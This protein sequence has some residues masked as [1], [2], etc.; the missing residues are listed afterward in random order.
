MLDTSYERFFATLANE[1]RL[2]IVQHLSKSGP[3]SV[4]DIVKATSLEQ[5]LV[6]RHMQRLLSCH[7]VSVEQDGKERI[8]ELNQDTIAPLLKL[9]DDH[10]DKYCSKACDDCVEGCACE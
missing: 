8:Y 10:V 2:S 9:I 5:S 3:Q 1:N 6:S 4:T 7:F